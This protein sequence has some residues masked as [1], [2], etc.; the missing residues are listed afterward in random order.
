MLLFGHLLE[1]VIPEGLHSQAFSPL[2]TQHYVIQLM[3]LAVQL[4]LPKISACYHSIV[5]SMSLS[6]GF[7]DRVWHCINNR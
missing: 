5:P 2:G 4:L 1:A 7:E 6:W 3:L